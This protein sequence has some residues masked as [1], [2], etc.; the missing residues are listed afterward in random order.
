MIEWVG[1][2]LAMAS[3]LIISQKNLGIAMFVSAF[4]LG[5]FMMPERLP[6][7]VLRYL[8]DPSTILLALIVGFIPLIGGTLSETGQ[9][10]ELISN[11]RIGKKPF[12][13]LSPALIG[14]LPMPGGALLSAPIVDK[15]G[16]GISKEVKMGINVWFRHILYLVYPIS[17][18]FIVSTAAARIGLYHPIPHLMVITL[19]SLMLGYLFLLRGSPGRMEYEESLS[20]RGL[21]LPLT[22]L[23]IAPL[24]D[25]LLKVSRALLVEEAGTLIAVAASLIFSIAIGKPSLK[26]F[27]EITTNARPWSFAFMMIGIMVFLGVFK[28]SGVLELFKDAP[29]TPEVLYVIAVALGFMTGRMITPAGIVFPIYL[30][31]F[32]EV[33]ALTFALIYFGIFLGYVMTPVHPCV[34]LTA[35][36]LKVEMK[37]YLRVMLPP[38]TMGLAVSL[39]IL[40]FV[41]P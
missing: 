9:I 27:I 18:N 17:A 10:D 11:M 14:L 16:R 23:L 33:S 7:V 22:A 29:M 24:I 35:E 40:H 4:I 21:A 32:G 12:L 30:M 41:N 5:V 2:S 20:L 34:S 8:T 37:D 31:K 6:F 26:K 3:L 1:F 19:F 28:N 36:S 25:V 13:M 39:T 38:V 15:A